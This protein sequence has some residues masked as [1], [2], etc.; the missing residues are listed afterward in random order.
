MAPGDKKDKPKEKLS[1][2]NF[3]VVE[4]AVLLLFLIS[5]LGSLLP[6]LIDYVTSGEI[7]FYGYQ[8]GGVFEFFKSRSL[9][10][11]FLGFSIAGAGAAATLVLTKM[12]DAIWR[13]EK[14][15]LYPENIPTSE[16]VIDDQKST[17]QIYERWQD[18]L[19][20]SESENPSDW[21]FAIIEADILLDEL[22]DQL[23]LPGNTIG[24]K[25][26]AVEPS[27]F[28]TLDN[29]WEAHKARNQI[30][31]Q[32]SNFLLNQHETRRIIALYASVFK[33]FGLI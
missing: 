11:K 14:A 13:E 19:K 15:K 17:N 5:I 4:G 24:D 26:K 6:T 10:F 28:L 33:E 21:R 7:S 8:L 2:W 31:H 27:D 20:H 3:G 16:N 29:A 1:G 23:R 25:L 30:A 18:I 9:F 32:G 12:G 22:L